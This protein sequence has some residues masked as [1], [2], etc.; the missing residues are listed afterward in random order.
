[1]S[2]GAALP[3]SGNAFV[4]GCRAGRWTWTGL[5]AVGVAGWPRT[6]AIP[7]TLS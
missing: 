1:M 4:P 3:Y 6:H 7:E 5:Q 2:E